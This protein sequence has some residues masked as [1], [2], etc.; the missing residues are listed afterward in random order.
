MKVATPYEVNE[1]K[2]SISI[3]VDSYVA[4]LIALAGLCIVS[5]EFVFFGK[6]AALIP[7]AFACMFAVTMGMR[8]ATWKSRLVQMTAIIVFGVLLFYYLN[9]RTPIS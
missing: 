6:M 4:G 8:F 2:N 3:Q 5:L 9:A 1:M 7:S